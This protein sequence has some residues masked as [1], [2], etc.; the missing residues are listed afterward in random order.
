MNDD[1]PEN[2]TLQIEIIRWNLCMM[3]FT[4]EFPNANSVVK[5]RLNLYTRHE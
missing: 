4:T 1:G 3:Q 5:F 2:L